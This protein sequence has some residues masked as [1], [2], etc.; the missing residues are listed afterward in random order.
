MGDR[1]W[2]PELNIQKGDQ[3]WNLRFCPGMEELSAMM[4]V[5]QYQ[6]EQRYVIVLRP[7]LIHI[8]KAPDGQP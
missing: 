2:I 1:L 5:N 7:A 3:A 8:N 4:Y 6:R